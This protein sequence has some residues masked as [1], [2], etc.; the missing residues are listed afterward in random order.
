M[1]DVRRSAQLIMESTQQVRRHCEGLRDGP[2]VVSVNTLAKWPG[3]FREI[4]KQVE[5]AVGQVVAITGSPA[6]AEGIL[7]KHFTWLMRDG[8]EMTTP[9]QTLAGVTAA[10]EILMAEYMETWSPIVASTPAYSAL[11][12]D[13]IS[14]HPEATLNIASFKPHLSAFI[15]ALP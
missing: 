14:P 4:N 12:A 6:I 9:L 10:G 11:P 15:N 7:A 3:K 5:T 13:R 1:L 8:Q 2:D